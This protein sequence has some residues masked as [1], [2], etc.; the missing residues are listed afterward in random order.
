MFDNQSYVLFP[1]VLQEFKLDVNCWSTFK[2]GLGKVLEDWDKSNPFLYSE[3][4]EFL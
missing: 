3:Q 1:G 4:Q 2:D